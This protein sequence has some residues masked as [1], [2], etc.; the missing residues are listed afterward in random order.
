VTVSVESIGQYPVR[1]LF[2]EA[3]DILS[4]KC[5]ELQQGL[6]QINS[7]ADGDGDGDVIVI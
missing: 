3:V 4:A 2:A 5:S 1:E 7:A 6:E